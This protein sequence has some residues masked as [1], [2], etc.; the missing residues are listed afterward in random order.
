MRLDAEILVKKYK[1]SLF[2]CAFNI[3]KNEADADDAVQETFIK[4]HESSRQFENE[5]HI[6]AWLIRVVINKARDISFSFWR[7]KMTPL[8][9]YMETLS[10][11]TPEDSA[12]FETVMNLPEKLRLVLH[13]YYY[14]DY[15]IRE[16]A[17]VLKISENNVKVRLNRGRKLLKEKLKEEWDDDEQRKI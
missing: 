7:R 14:E 1:D 2:A 6:K 16:I 12:L 10:F 5:Q 13:L 15:S 9:D 4:Y 11:D 17:E 8:E 3:C